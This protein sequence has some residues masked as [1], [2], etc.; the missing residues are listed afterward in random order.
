MNKGTLKTTLAGLSIA[1]LLA[2]TM[3]VGGCKGMSAC[4]CSDSKEH[5]DKQGE[6]SCGKGSCGGAKGNT[7]K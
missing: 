4:S 5:E 1:G 3:A 6:H 7:S 2:G